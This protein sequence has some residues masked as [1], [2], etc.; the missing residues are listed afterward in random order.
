[1]KIYHN[2]RCSKSR[3]AIGYLEDA[4]VDF[5]VV[6]YLEETPSKAEIKD[7]LKKLGIKAEELVRKGEQI[8]KDNY[9]GKTLSEEEWIDAMA[10]HPRLIERPIIV[11]GDRA[12]IGRPPEKVL[13]FLK[14]A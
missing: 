1:M 2:T 12:I 10:E 11:D 13:E 9:R 14:K 6:K 7:L 3:C 8:F 5:E 4:D